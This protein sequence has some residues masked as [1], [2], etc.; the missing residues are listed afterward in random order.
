MI[1]LLLIALLFAGTPDQ[2]RADA[3][4]ATVIAA[5]DRQ[6]PDDLTLIREACGSIRTMQCEF[7][8]ERH[9]EMLS[10]KP[11]AKGRMWFDGKNVRWE[12]ISPEPFL[13]IMDGTSVLLQGKERRISEIKTDRRFSRIAKLAE[14]N[15]ILLGQGLGDIPDFDAALTR[16]KGVLIV[17]LTP[18]RRDFQLMF[19]MVRLHFG[20]DYRVQKIELMEKGSDR[21]VITLKNQKYNA[22]IPAKTFEIR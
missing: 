4:Q 14:G 3:G 9:L 15:N 18:T 21:T 11:V 17:E 16:E 10:D 2:V 6:T 1:R 8:Q 22:E 13:F 19:R 12:Y 5:P 20:A 7:V